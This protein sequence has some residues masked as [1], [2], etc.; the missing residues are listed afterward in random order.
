MMAQFDYLIVGQGLA[1]SI[2]AWELLNRH[3]SVLVIDRDDDNTASKVAAGLATPIS[4]R[5][6]TITPEWVSMW[7]SAR[8]FYRSLFDQRAQRFFSEIPYLRLFTSPAQRDRFFDNA[9]IREL[10]VNRDPHIDLDLFRAPFGGFEINGGRLDC[11]RFLNATSD[12]LQ[13]RGLRIAG[14]ITRADL[15][16]GH[17]EINIPKFGVRTTQIIFCDGASARD[18][19][20][21]DFIEFAPAKGEILQAR[22]PGYRESRIVSNGLWISPIGGEICNVGATFNRNEID[23]N[24]TQDARQNI[25]GRLDELLR[26]PYE[27]LDQRAAVRPILVDRQAIIGR[28]PS[29]PRIAFFNGLGSKGVVTGPYLAAQLAD[30]LIS[31]QPIEKRYRVSER[32]LDNANIH[33]IKDQRLTAVAHKLVTKHL[34]SGENAVDATAGNGLDTIFLA[35]HVADIGKVYAFDIQS[36]ALARCGEKLKLAGLNNVELIHDCH[37]KIASRVPVDDGEPIAVVMFNLGYLPKGDHSISTELETTQ[38]A[39]AAALSAIRPGGLVTIIC[40][41]GHASGHRETAGVLEMLAALDGSKFQVAHYRVAG[42]KKLAPQL[43]A[44]VKL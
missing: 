36:V 19:P 42:T 2:L 20:L 17:S 27:V 15:Q 23:D 44:V 10:D 34:N 18:N 43:V 33:W 30:Y 6:L 13:S 14:E 39:I 3:V 24:C 21:F 29:N 22:I 4:G 31:G 41:P 5:N 38:I 25:C 28:H 11:G 1:G 26:I 40:Y 35:Q 32:G 7:G 9:L 8:G 16:M 37:S 12:M